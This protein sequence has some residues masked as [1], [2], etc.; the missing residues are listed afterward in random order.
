MFQVFGISSLG[1]W[2]GDG[3]GEMGRGV[4]KTCV[5]GKEV[6][7]PGAVVPTIGKDL[8]VAVDKLVQVS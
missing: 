2:L 6:C 7:G 3:K 8:F 1:I 5:W 4:N